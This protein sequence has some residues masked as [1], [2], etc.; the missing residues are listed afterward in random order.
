MPAQVFGR[1]NAT[2]PSV[3]LSLSV[4]NGGFGTESPQAL[5]D[6]ARS[7]KTVLDISSQPALWGGFMRGGDDLLMSVSRT[8]YE[9]ASNED[10]A[11]DLVHAHLIETL[12]CLGRDSIDFYFLRVRRTMEEFQ[13][14]GALAALELAKQEGHI[15]HVGLFADGPPLAVLGLWQFHDAFEALLLPHNH[16]NQDAFSVL[17]GMAHNRRVGVVGTKSLDWGYGLSIDEIAPSFGVSAIADLS[18]KMPAIVT[19]RSVDDVKKFT[20]SLEKGDD[21]EERL[22]TTLAKFEDETTWQL[23]A[24]SDDAHVRKAARLRAEEM[25]SCF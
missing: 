2:V 11:T 14:N 21:F 4:P 6:A 18:A 12:S 15:Q 22:A 24:Q 3:W 7:A 8:Q 20:S 9:L 13:V 5:V 19:V 16:H 10:H 17:G 25:A 1:T 23:L